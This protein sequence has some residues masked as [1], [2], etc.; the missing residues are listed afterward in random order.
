MEKGGSFLFENRGE[1][2]EFL[3]SKIKQ[4]RK[5]MENRNSGQTI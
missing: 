2:P 3:E 1:P 4:N 5:S